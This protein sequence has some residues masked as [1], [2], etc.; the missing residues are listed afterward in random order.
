MAVSPLSLQALWHKWPENL[1]T[2]SPLCTCF[3]YPFIFWLTA[4]QLPKPG[5]VCALVCRMQ[6]FVFKS[7]PMRYAQIFVCLNLQSGFCQWHRMPERHTI[8]S[9][10][11]DATVFCEHRGRN[12]MVHVMHALLRL[13][14]LL[15]TYSLIHSFHIIFSFSFIM[16]FNL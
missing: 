6:L 2:P 3:T 10:I 14:L 12:D 8:T 13:C 9:I 7:I 5:L 4:F 11:S 1:L 16:L 15:N